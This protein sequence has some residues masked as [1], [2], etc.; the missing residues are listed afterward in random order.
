ML[1]L[2]TLTLAVGTSSYAQAA[3]RS[4]SRWMLVEAKP[5]GPTVTLDTRSVSGKDAAGRVTVW[6]EFSY[7]APGDYPHVYFHEVVDC[8]GHRIGLLNYT[9]YDAANPTTNM[10]KLDSVNYFAI[11]PG[12]SGEAIAKAV[13]AL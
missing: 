4:N 5:G 3:K 8:K 10:Q 1:A 7:P 2:V 11:E 6:V 9:E 13:C 12:S